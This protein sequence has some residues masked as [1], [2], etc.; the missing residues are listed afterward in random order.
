[1]MD[2]GALFFE[3]TTWIVV[4]VSYLY[5]IYRYYNLIMFWYLSASFIKLKI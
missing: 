4:T 3:P 1:M 5:Y 2:I